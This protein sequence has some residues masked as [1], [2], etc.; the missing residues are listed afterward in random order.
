MR[1]RPALVP[2]LLG[3][4]GEQWTLGHGHRPLF[5]RVLA[6]P[7]KVKPAIYVFMYVFI[8]LFIICENFF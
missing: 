1:R 4:A 3:Q 8:Y 2:P 7:S 5:A 6:K